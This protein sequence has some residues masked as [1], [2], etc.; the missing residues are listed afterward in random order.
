MCL[1]SV[2]IISEQIA[3]T[4]LTT[5]NSRYLILAL[6]QKRRYFLN[7]ALCRITCDQRFPKSYCKRF[8]EMAVAVELFRGK[9]KEPEYP[10]YQPRPTYS[11]HDN[12]TVL[13]RLILFPLCCYLIHLPVF[14]YFFILMVRVS[15]KNSLLPIF[16]MINSEDWSQNNFT[17]TSLSLWRRHHEE[18][19]VR[20]HLW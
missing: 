18:S 5:D 17:N 2:L 6:I 4:R 3:T 15:I 11:P 20:L 12:W 14:S 9:P 8:C 16:W 10:D 19:V 7:L 13:C 1:L